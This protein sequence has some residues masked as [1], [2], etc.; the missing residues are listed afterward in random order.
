VISNMLPPAEAIK[1]G[2]QPQL[3]ADNRMVVPAGVPIAS[4]P[5]VPT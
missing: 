2:E 3:A 4:R 5:P 1:R